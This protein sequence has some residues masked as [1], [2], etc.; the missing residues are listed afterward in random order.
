MKVV[1]KE[2]R[3]FASIGNSKLLMMVCDVLRNI[4]KH[5]PFSQFE[6]FSALKIMNLKK[7]TKNFYF[8]HSAAELT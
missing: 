1:L 4:S 6:P 5:K 8:S 3:S 7:Y 2:M